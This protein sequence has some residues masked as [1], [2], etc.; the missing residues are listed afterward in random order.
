MK[1][2]IALTVF[3]ISLALNLALAVLGLGRGAVWLAPVAM[4]V[5]WYLADFMSGLIHMYMD[6]IPCTPGVGLAEIYFYEG[7]R[8]SEDYIRLRDQA[9][10]RISPFEKVA[11]DFKN[12]H[13]RPDALG[14]RDLVF[15]VK[16]TVLFISLPFSLALNLACLVWRPPGWLVMGLVVFLVGGTLSQ[17]FHGS[18]HRQRNPAIVTLFRR[19][20]L[21]MTPTAHGLHHATLTQ[22]FSVINGWSN[23][24]LNLIF[25]AL[26]RWRVITPAGLEPT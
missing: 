19:V 7:S 15:Q 25:R 22:D 23:P 12:H 6:Y 11:Y 10:A 20:G 8:E 16:A 13:P 17:Y 21:L 5:G 4:L 24:A 1:T 9:W 3:L 2:K 14:R 26:M 18:L